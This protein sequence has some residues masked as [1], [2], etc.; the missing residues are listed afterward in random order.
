MSVRDAIAIVG[1]GCRFAGGAAD[2]A[3]FWRLLAE[4]RDA[5]API[6]TGRWDHAAWVGTE[7]GRTAQTAGGFLS[8]ID[9]FDNAFFGIAPREAV[10]MDPQQ[11]LVLEVAWEALENAGSAPDRLRGVQGG[12]YLGLYNDNYG[13]IG[14]GSP[15][16]TLIDGWSASGT[17]TSVAPG[18]IAFQLGLTGPAIAIDSACSS[19]LTAVHL[20]VQALRAGDCTMALAGGV[21]LIL[22]PLGLVASTKLGAASAS[23]HCKAFDADADGFVHGEGCGVLVLKRLSDAEAA[24]D[25]VLAVI[26]G[27]A[28]NQ[29]GRSAGLTAPNGPAQEAVIRAALTNAGLTPDSID[30]IEAHGTGTALG[31][32][33]E[34]HALASVFAGRSKP[35]SV[36]SVKTN[37]GHTEAAAGVA[38]LIKAVLMLRHQSVPATLHFKQLNPHI[39]LGGVPIEVPT[40]TRPTALNRIG[41]S[42]FGFSGTN[43]HV[44]LE[45][46]P[47]SKPAADPRPAQVLAI[48]ARDPAALDALRTRWLDALSVPAADLAGLA[49]ATAGR[50]RFAHRMAVVASDVASARTALAAA[51][52]SVGGRPRV[53]FLCTGQGSTY[54]GMAAGLMDI[55]PVFRSVIERCDAVMGLDAPLARIFSDAALLARTDYAQPALYALSAALGTLWRSWGIEPVAVLGHSV[56]EYAAAHLAGVLTLED[57]ARLIATRGKLMQALP[58]GGAMA[59]LLGAEAKVR[60]VLAQHP[61]IELAGLNSPTAM[62]VAGPEAAIDRL[63]ADPALSGMA[64]KL[65]LA[66][67]F[68]SRLLDPMLDGLQAAAEATPHAEPLIPVVGNLAGEVVARHDGAYWRAH[69]RQPVRFAAGLETL[70]KMGVTHLVELGAQ[71]VLS[72]FARTAAAEIAAL[73]SLTRARPNVP[74]DK[75]GWT[76]LLEGLARLWRDGSPVDWARHHAPY[77]TAA[78]D[79]P[80]YPFQRQSYWLADPTLDKNALPR[81]DDRATVPVARHASEVGD[82]KVTGFYDELAQ[83]AGHDDAHADGTEGHLTFGLMSGPQPDFSWL[84]AFF[85]GE[86]SPDEYATLRRCQSALKQ[87]IFA[88][89]DFGQA[90]RVLDFGCGHAADLCA[91]ANRHP[92][93]ALDGCTISAGQVAVGQRRVARLGLQNRVRLHHRD[94]ARDPF[95]GRFDVIFGVEVAGLIED[96]Q[97]LFDNIAQHLEPGGALVIADFVA[98]T[99]LIASP[100]TASFTPTADEWAK[101][102]TSH[103]LRLTDC[104]DVS[105]EVAH[106]L[107]HPGAAA[108]VEKAVKAHNLS[109]LTRTHL[110]S[111]D[112]IGKA[113]RAGLMRYNLL[114][115]RHDR[116]TPRDRLLAANRARLAAPDSWTPEET[117]R[118]WFYRVVWQASPLD[119]ALERGRATVTAHASD[120]QAVDRL[121]RAYVGAADL[122]SAKPVPRMARLHAHLLATQSGT[123]DP[124]TLP[125]PD[126]PESHL[127][128]RCGPRLRDVIEGNDDPLDALFGDGGA[129]AEALYAASPFARAV[130]DIA[131]AG[132]DSLLDGRRP[133]TVLEIGCGTGGTTK[134]LLPRL[135]PGDR[136]LATDISPRFVTALHQQL[137]VQGSMLDI[138][139]PPKDQGF[140]DGSADIVVAANVLHATESL[141]ATLANTMPLLAPDGALLL[142]ENSGPLVWGDLT[143]GLT[144]GMWAFADADLRPRHAL[145]T[146]ATWITLLEE[147]GL[148]VEIFQPGGPDTAALSGQFVLLARRRPAVA[149]R[150]WFAPKTA[151][152]VGLLD[153]A[154]TELR[155]AAAE[156]GPPRV[157]MVT[158]GARTVAAG[159]R[160]DVAQAALWGMANSVAIE[161]P[162]LRLTMIDTAD[163]AIAARMVAS[164]RGE[165]RLAVRA[166][167][168]LQARLEHC[169]PG[170]MVPSPRP[171]RTY[172]VTGGLAGVGLEVGRW[173]AASG[174]RS[175]ALLGRTAHEIDDFPSGVTVTTHVC[176]VADETALVDVL[177]RLKRERPPLAGIFHA[178]GVLDDAML[179]QQTPER[180]ARVLAPKLDGGRLLDRLT[181]DLPIEHFVLFSSSAALLGSAAQANH[182]AA[183]ACLDA[184][185]ETRRAEGLPAVSI[186]WGAWADVGAA[187]RAGAAVARRGLLPM[188]P[189]VALVALG[190]AMASADPVVGVLDVDWSRFLDRFP[191]GTRPPLFA[192][193][194]P[195][196]AVPKTNAHDI[197]VAAQPTKRSLA[198][199]LG[200]AAPDARA[201]ILLDHVRTTTATILGLRDELP[202]AD[203]P[204]REVGLDSLM[205]VEL[206]NALATACDTRLPATLVFEY[207]TCAALADR[208]AETVFADLVPRAKDAAGTDLESMDADGLAAL[209]EQELGAAD[210]QLAVSR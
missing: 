88:A 85:A 186:A 55:S 206:R 155:A 133:A 135:R 93:L 146:P 79:A 189:H 43:A 107:D 26:R 147:A 122:A 209:L 178:A 30:A 87:A 101:L 104:V 41:V 109:A 200:E 169:P 124:D 165:T 86:A 78:A 191:T 150:V 11:R 172:L 74:A 77:R 167:R 31:D 34:M 33:I 89:V 152:T 102:L 143:F 96:K 121:A 148:S 204:L 37:I 24:G 46:A 144:D 35:L 32:P 62:T 134:T 118:N 18:R 83:A 129:A 120:A 9:M 67:A 131:A 82:I 163:R 52:P 92:H 171:D 193:M 44:V 177:D 51:T 114:T 112:N 64:L 47:E 110:L 81:R 70:K 111:N 56:G 157:W 29:D 106:Y 164:G 14:R 17:H 208:L 49:R 199:L 39:D 68:H 57:G 40:A 210:A 183:N 5:V 95:P 27:T 158:D 181:R 145:P 94:S 182:A 20:A 76:T 141:R 28:V 6:P 201:S 127:L 53:A 100:D 192:N 117:W 42:S 123:E 19:S 16:A 132:L 63:V 72:G 139:R 198:S 202:P 2:G 98:V 203:A 1:L 36:G 160:I 50:A 197:T 23:G 45:R 119:E 149:D 65:P 21:H 128:R 184:L 54:A 168:V 90:R 207:P 113:L 153:A 174:A 151:D 166:G 159:D 140:A 97:A 116:T 125:T 73:P 194:A 4:A 7:P 162:D 130:N 196:D 126:L 15:D 103:G 161:H 48:S 138:S 38:G 142:I 115:A 190:H 173:L 188:A 205:T 12:I 8:D 185:A 99:D 108:E 170:E 154:A 25:R 80:A 61:E 59:A 66:H 136:Y 180:I 187:A 13:L 195:A 179:A 58:T 3:G 60:A 137:G 22:S 176:D 91:I 69:A 75:H 156:L 71:P 175:I 84:R 10:Q 105:K